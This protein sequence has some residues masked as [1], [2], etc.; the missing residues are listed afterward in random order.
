MYSDKNKIIELSY[1]K[2]V[3]L[4]DGLCNLCNNSI[5]FI[6]KHDRKKAFVF[7]AIQSDTGQA[8]TGSNLQ[9]EN[10]LYSIL[11]LYRGEIYDRSE[12]ML[13]VAEIIGGMWAMAS[14]FRILPR[15]F[16]DTLY[17]FVAR[18]RYRWFGKR[19]SCMLPDEEIK[20]RFLD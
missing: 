15:S 20:S 10:N 17:D 18:R 13:K 4:F 19:D 7:S 2:P 9:T 14:I 8:I 1:A 5:R 12:A 11:L 6:I 16:R 3:I